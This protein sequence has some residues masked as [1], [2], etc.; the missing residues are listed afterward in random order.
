MRNT[1]T[2]RRP[3]PDDPGESSGTALGCLLGLSALLARPAETFLR[4]PRTAGRHYFRGA[5]L[6]GLVVLVFVAAADPV[7][8]RAVFGIGGFALAFGLIHN[9]AAALVA[10][11]G[12][13]VHRRYA[14]DSWFAGRVVSDRTAKRLVEPAATAG[15]GL[16]LFPLAP[17]LGL[18]F[19][20][21]G[22]ALAVNYV[23]WELDMT[24]RVAGWNDAA[25]EAADLGRRVRRV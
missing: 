6:G 14:G 23:H 9:N 7:N 5:L 21:A 16:L 17:A 24:D 2:A 15:F 18:Y 25:I 10:R 1:A 19:V 3:N 4:R 13:I 8:A 11:E 22:V 20:A 12:G